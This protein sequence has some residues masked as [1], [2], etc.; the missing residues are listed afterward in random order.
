[1]DIDHPEMKYPRR[2]YPLAAQMA[3][4]ANNTAT[5]LPCFAESTLCLKLFHR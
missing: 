3:Q 1:M 4:P 2:P 5:P